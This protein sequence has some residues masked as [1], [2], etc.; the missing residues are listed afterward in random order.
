MT[1]SCIVPNYN[2]APFLEERLDSILAQ[3]RVPDEII[4]LD[5]CSTDDSRDI[6]KDYA[7]RYPN[8]ISCHFNAENSGGPFPQW[9]RGVEIAKG[10]IIWIAESD[11]S[12]HPTFL[13][14]TCNLLEADATLTLSYTQSLNI[15]RGGNHLGNLLISGAPHT[16]GKWDSDAVWEADEMIRDS[17]GIFCSIPNAS[18]A[19]F[20]KEAYLQD[21]GADESLRMAGDWKTWLSIAATGGRIAYLATPLNLHRCHGGT[22]RSAKVATGTNLLESYKV[23]KWADQCGILEPETK[24]LAQ[25]YFRWVWI[26][27][28]GPE[29]Q[30]TDNLNIAKE[31]WK[32]DPKASIMAL[33]MI[34]KRRLGILKPL[35]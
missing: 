4:L 8:L 15:D 33:R 16:P 10:D 23:L 13:E 19:V 7:E 18:S 30:T 14:T 22:V 1:I 5:D 12:S 26:L 9:N 20:R 35:N 29:R 3:T 31:A 11:D 34:L 2:H 6:L 28:Q 32:F 27:Q 17:L 25:A 24:R 21:G